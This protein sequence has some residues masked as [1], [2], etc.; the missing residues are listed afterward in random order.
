MVDSADSVDL[1]WATLCYSSIPNCVPEQSI[2]VF[3]G[4]VKEPTV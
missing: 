1:A 3:P 4:L 2:F